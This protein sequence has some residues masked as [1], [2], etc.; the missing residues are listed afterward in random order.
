MTSQS[1]R[2][3]KALEYCI[4]NT[5]NEYIHNN[6]NKPSTLTNDS[7]LSIA[8]FYFDNLDIGMKADFRL[9]SS[10]ISEKILE[11]NSK[12]LQTPSVYSKISL[13]SDHVARNGNDVRDIVVDLFSSKHEKI[14]S[15]GISSK[16]N[17]DA[18][19][20]SRISGTIDFGN[21]WYGISVSEEYKNKTAPIFSRLEENRKKPWSEHTELK[22]E[23]YTK[24]LNE[25]KDEIKR[26]PQDKIAEKLVRYLIG[27]TDYYKTI[28]YR[29]RV[30]IVDYN[31][32]GTLIGLSGNHAPTALP[33]KI[34]SF[35]YKERTDNT[36]I[37]RMDEGWIISF[38]I[39]NASSKI[40]P[41]LKFDIRIL[42]K[43]DS[44]KTHTF[45]K[46]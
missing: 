43:P 39:H 4:A 17:N 23:V 6:L 36:L 37:M 31:L 10:I 32:N 34:I 14:H 18:A 27:A 19:R 9:A 24:I 44:I 41:S 11:P 2:Y 30:E 46:S 42:E 1:T 22:K 7:S 28:N 21:T 5:M 3:G 33:K 8:K 25:F 13:Q 35:D 29:D 26:G 45:K 20:H 16:N 40:E 12:Y 15:F 38:R